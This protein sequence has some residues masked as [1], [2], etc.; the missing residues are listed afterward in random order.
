MKKR[1]DVRS[2]LTTPV[3]E[4]FAHAEGT[5]IVIDRAAHTAA[6]LDDTDTVIEL[7]VNGGWQD[8]LASLNTAKVAGVNVPTWA[9]LVGGISA[10]SFSATVMNEVWLSLHVPHD[11][12]VGTMIYPHI[13]WAPATNAAGTV[14]WGIEYSYA[15]GY[16]VDAFPATSTLYIEQASNQVANSHHI[17]EPTE[18]NG[19]NIAT[20]ETDGLLLMRVFRDA[21]HANDTL[22]AATFGL[23]ADLHY[24]S[25][26]LL[27]N[28]R[29]RTFTKRRGTEL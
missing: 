2:K 6:I 7:G 8:L 16:G 14:R 17:A 26:G 3:V 18:G 15:R 5:P 27:T 19:L 21:A 22:G 24:Q 28:E 9:A 4:D 13:H 11:Y 12:K 20:L 25:D 29:N 10:Y 23:F 1:A